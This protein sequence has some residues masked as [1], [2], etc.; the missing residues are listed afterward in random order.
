M[1]RVL[2]ILAVAATALLGQAISGSTLG[3]QTPPPPPRTPMERMAEA[4]ARRGETFGTIEGVVTDTALRPVQGADIAVIGTSVRLKTGANGRFR[5]FQIPRGQYLLVV[6]QIGYAPTSAILDIAA[7]DT[8]RLSY[9]L[10]RSTNLLDT[11]RVIGT[12][13]SLRMLDFERRRQQGI[14]QFIT[15]EY[16]EKRGSL[17]V[18]DFLRTLRGVDV[19]RLTG[20]EFQGTIA[21]SRRE[22]GSLGGDGANACA[23][24][25]LLDGI[26]LPRNFN[27]DLL[28][29][30][31][32]ISGIEVYTGAATVPP[33]FGGVDRRC[34]LIAVW[35]RDG[36]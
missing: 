25:V 21:L 20:E 13:V 14:G 32:Q 11:M 35:T 36:Y 30:P 23:M 5:L 29:T 34:G 9:A 4:N 6:R 3:A 17:A 15:Q 16:I 18:S 22:G 10:E 2:C 26:V 8:L 12:R 24:Q 28:P 1:F 33:Q 31:K 7:D 19:S 27:L